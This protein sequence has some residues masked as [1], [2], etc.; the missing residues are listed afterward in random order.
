MSTLAII[1]ARG[2]SKRIP[3]K[4][5]REFNGKPIIAYSIEAAIQSGVFDTVMVSTDDEE[6]A[7]IAKKYGAEVPFMRSAATSDD[8]A[9]TS[10]VLR[11]VLETY[12]S[13][14][15]KYDIAACIYPTAPF[16]T[17]EKLRTA[18]DT[19]SGEAGSASLPIG[20]A[21]PD[22][23]TVMPVVRFSYPPQRSYE[24]KEGYL[25]FREPEYL[26]ASSQDL[27][28]LYHDAGQFYVFKPESFLRSGRITKGNIVPMEIPETEVQDIDTEE[29]WE[30]AEIK[31]R[32]T[33]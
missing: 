6:I 23:D 33:H 32:M 19:L 12:A 22:A 27:T 21:N 15:V 2:G 4:N 31:Y 24:I 20:K 28:P 9:T 14:G 1:T 5:I 7:D 29:D 8:H 16:I 3:R 25:R 10:D 18:V 13:K 30:L 26:D 17:A 11:E